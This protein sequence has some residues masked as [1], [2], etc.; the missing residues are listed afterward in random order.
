[1]ANVGGTN[2]T[3]VYWKDGT[4]VHRWYNDANTDLADGQT[5]TEDNTVNF[6]TD[7]TTIQ[8]DTSIKITAG[9]NNQVDELIAAIEALGAVTNDTLTGFWFRNAGGT[10]HGALGG[11]VTS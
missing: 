6:V 11:D 9:A 5:Q 7:N 4:N 8:T 3:A 10:P 1:M 2:N